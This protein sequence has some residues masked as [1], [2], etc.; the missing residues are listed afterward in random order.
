MPHL[1]FPHQIN[2]LV[3]FRQMLHVA[4]DVIDSGRV[5][6]DHEFGYDMFRR[7]LIPSR[8]FQGTIEEQI[9]GYQA[10]EISRQA[11]LTTARD[12]RRTFKLFGLLEEIGEEFKITKRGEVLTQTR[13]DGDLTNEERTVWLEGLANLKFYNATDPESTN[14]DFRVRPFLLMLELLLEVGDLEN[15]L[16]V[17]A[18]T[19]INE[20]NTEKERIRSLVRSIVSGGSR[21]EN[22]VSDAGLT[23]SNARNNVKI[24]PSIGI[25]LGLIQR[26][27]EML[28]I[29]PLGE[30]FYQ[31]ETAKLPI[32]Y[33]YLDVPNENLRRATVATLLVIKNIDMPV[34]IINQLIRGLDVNLS[35][36]LD[37]FSNNRIGVETINDSLHLVT[38]ISFDIYQDVPPDIRSREIFRLVRVLVEEELIEEQADVLEPGRVV[39]EVRRRRIG[40]VRQHPSKRRIENRNELRRSPTGERGAER[41]RDEETRELI[42]ERNNEHQEI[43]MAFFD[44]YNER[45]MHV[46]YSN[47]FDLL[48]EKENIALIHEMKTLTEENEREQIMKGIGQLFYY[49]HF[50]LPQVLEDH[51]AQ[52]VK[53]IVFQKSLT[54]SPHIEFIKSLGIHVFWIGDDSRIEGE[55]E[56]MAFLRSFLG[57]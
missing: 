37:V 4:K 25:Q 42:A 38:P 16:L 34:N 10:L 28:R 8:T 7:E 49:E 47:Y 43:L 9:R 46:F 54:Y 24:L 29:T 22:V 17:F 31:R 5:L 39:R 20:S 15:K 51:N 2:D 35:Q 44:L 23:L 27:G 11:P 55:A 56:S 53:A 6:N 40:R 41:G 36:V 50:A 3:K 32:W 18:M 45:G 33:K 21:F 1:N 52:V 12:V 14:R 13:L 19:A 26:V 30:S 57:V 48:V